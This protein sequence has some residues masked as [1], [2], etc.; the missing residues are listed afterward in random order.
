MR[1]G[2]TGALLTGIIL[3]KQPQGAMRVRFGCGIGR[4]GSAMCEL[5]IWVYE[6]FAMGTVTGVLIIKLFG[7]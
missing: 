7:G 6:I 2:N 1:C 3:R 4:I 5:G